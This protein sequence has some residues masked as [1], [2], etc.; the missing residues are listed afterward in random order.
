MTPEM[1]TGTLDEYRR[2]NPNHEFI[3]QEEQWEGRDIY[4][5]HFKADGELFP[6]PI[7]LLVAEDGSA[8]CLDAI[9]L[10]MIEFIRRRWGL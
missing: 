9:D 1:E 7:Y 8:E 4:E 3:K 2:C 6:L 5:V 10:D